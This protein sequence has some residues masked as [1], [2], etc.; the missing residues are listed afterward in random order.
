MGGFRA[1]F[2]VPFRVDFGFGGTLG[3][4]VRGDKIKSLG[5]QKRVFA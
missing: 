5:G 1:A 4:T 2:F 3:G